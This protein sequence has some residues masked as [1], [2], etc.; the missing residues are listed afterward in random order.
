MTLYK[1]P[2]THA[3]SFL[4]LLATEFEQALR[5]L[6]SSLPSH[7]DLVQYAMRSGHRTRPVGCLLAAEAVGGDWRSALN[8][9]LA[10]EL[11]HKSSVIRDDIMDG[12]IVRSGQPAFHVTFGIA[13]AIAVGD[14]LWTIALDQDPGRTGDLRRLCVD[15]LRQMAAG[16]LEDVVPSADRLS[17]R[18]R[19]LVEE[20]KTGALSELSCR[21][22]ATIG[23]GDA[24]QVDALALYGRNLGTAFQILNDLRNLRG[25]EPERRPGSDLRRH[26][27]TILAAHA[28]EV[29]TGVVRRRMDAVLLGPDELPDADVAFLREVILESGTA[30]FGER[31]AADLMED[32]R[33]QLSALTDSP[34]KEILR[35]L[36]EDALLAY[37]F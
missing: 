32:A 26:R 36:T 2:D 4:S 1:R 11:I 31:S 21:L 10:V 9:A 23:G 17:V 27:V 25:E 15:S 14:L 7:G 24:N 12:D 19:R 28:R 5:Q 6:I 20:R 3:D 18:D 37:A 35:S 8:S 16:Q 13:K 34:A 30:E 22:G 29:S 33:S